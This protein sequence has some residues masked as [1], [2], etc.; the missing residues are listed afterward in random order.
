MG[1]KCVQFV[2]RTGRNMCI[3]RSYAQSLCAGLWQV[4]TNSVHPQAYAAFLHR[5]FRAD[6]SW[7]IQGFCAPST[8]PITT[9]MCLKNKKTIKGGLRR[10]V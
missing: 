9:T 10:S 3:A 7:E 1:K 5:L 2:G 4:C 6:Y 8:G